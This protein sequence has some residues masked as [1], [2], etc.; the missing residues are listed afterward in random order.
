MSDSLQ[1]CELQH[2]RLPCPS[3]TPGVCSNSCPLSRWCHP[4]ISSSVTPS[5]PVLNLFCGIRVFSNVLALRIRW[6]KYWSFSFSISPSSAYWQRGL[7][8]VSFVVSSKYFM[9]FVSK[10]NTGS[11]WF[12]NCLI[13]YQFFLT[14]WFSGFY[15]RAQILY[16]AERWT[17]KKGNLSNRISIP[18]S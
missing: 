7:Y 8:V 11:N 3:P 12:F 18:K 5:P 9:E 6:P 2:A 14:A 16:S 10:D 13:F 4:T 1:P 17:L 15:F